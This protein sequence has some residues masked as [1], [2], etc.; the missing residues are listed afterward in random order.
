MLADSIAV[1]ALNADALSAEVV[2]GRDL[3]AHDQIAGN[4]MRRAVDATY[5]SLWFFGLMCEAGIGVSTAGAR[6]STGSGRGEPVEP[7]RA[8]RKSAKNRVLPGLV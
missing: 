1:D 5:F 2:E 8:Q 7:R 6:P 3:L 4:F